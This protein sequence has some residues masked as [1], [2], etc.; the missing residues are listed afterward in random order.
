MKRLYINTYQ[1]SEP[2]TDKHG[3]INVYSAPNALNRNI[4]KGG[5]L[6]SLNDEVFFL[7]L[8]FN[9]SQGHELIPFRSLTDL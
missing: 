4:V 3:K 2:R 1:K 7:P 5:F 9:L 6:P 8:G